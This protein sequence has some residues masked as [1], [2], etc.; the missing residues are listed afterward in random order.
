MSPAPRRAELRVIRDHLVLA[1]RALDEPLTIGRLPDND[2]VLDD[3]RV[4]GHHGRLARDGAHWRFTDVGST[5]GSAIAGGPVLHKG[6]SCVLREDS[7]ILLGGTVLDLRLGEAGAAVDGAGDAR[8][9]ADRSAADAGE[10]ADAATASAGEAARGGAARDGA[11]DAASDASPPAPVL[12]SPPPS[13]ASGIDAAVHAP[14]AGVVHSAFAPEVHAPSDATA[15]AADD[16]RRA[17]A[18]AGRPRVVVVLAGRATTAVLRGAS[19]V[20]GRGA[21]CDVRIED[22]SVSALHARLD[23]QQGRW[24]LTDLASRNGTRLGLRRVAGPETVRDGDHII[25]GAADLLFLIDDAPTPQARELRHALDERA[26]EL[27][28]RGRL[29]GTTQGRAARAALATG[30]QQ[31]GE[32]LVTQSWLSP[33]AWVELQSEAL[34]PEAG[35]ALLARTRRRRRILVALLVAAALALAAWLALAGGRA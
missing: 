30:S 1:A 31:L 9:G 7:Q 4:S 28:Q 5:N 35:D 15:P 8:A 2:L 32:F 14:R 13:T 17:A 27:A 3:D 10:S 16:S 24:L 12:L 19:A 25:V 33:G 26:L 6:E 21:S 18:P 20:I 11:I 23:L 34:V 22:D 29:L